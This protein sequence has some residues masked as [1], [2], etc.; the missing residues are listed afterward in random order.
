MD[1]DVISYFDNFNEEIDALKS[2]LEKK[3]DERVKWAKD[4]KG[5]IKKLFPKLNKI[6]VIEEPKKNLEYSHFLE[7]HG[8][9]EVFYF[10]PTYLNFCP[11]NDFRHRDRVYPTVKG[12]VLDC[13]LKIIYDDIRCFIN[14]LKELETPTELNKVA[15]GYTSIYI[16]ID[17][18]T[19]FY[20]I[21]RS[22]NPLL[23]EKTLQ[24]E[25]PTI[26][27]LYAFD[28]KIRYEKELHQMFAD[29][30]VRGEWFDLNGTDICKI[31]NFFENN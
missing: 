29:K 16:M 28:G 19:G 10:K 20:K 5:N 21:G 3:F 8:E 7:S 9:D 31:K 17:K 4:N 23:R 18:N 25:K 13:N 12:N 30:R 1:I 22:K 11:T 14:A 24:S 26:E 15:D 6:Y 27:M 2:L